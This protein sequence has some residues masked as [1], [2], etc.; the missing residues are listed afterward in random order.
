MG[1]SNHPET[2]QMK[3]TKWKDIAEL[4]GIAAIVLSLI[5]V[6]MET[7]NGTIQAELNTRALELAAYQQLIENIAHMN[8]L[9]IENP[10]MSEAINKA[11]DAP[12]ELSVSERRAVGSWLFLRFRHGDMAYFQ[13]ERGA[14]DE[15]RL[16]SAL[17][18]LIRPVQQTGF[19]LRWLAADRLAAGARLAAVAIVRAGVAGCRCSVSTT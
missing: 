3:S 7:R 13:Y 15:L 9:S 19:K 1:P 10:G 16:R 6:G 11:W 2:T 8:T 17:Q 12:S 18:P 5:F 14:I 4:V